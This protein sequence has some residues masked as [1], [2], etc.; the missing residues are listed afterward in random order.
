MIEIAGGHLKNGA[1][2]SEGQGRLKCAVAFAQQ[3]ADGVLAGVRRN[4]IEFAVEVK[5]GDDYSYWI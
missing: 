1:A 4:H 5:V 2:R 3:D